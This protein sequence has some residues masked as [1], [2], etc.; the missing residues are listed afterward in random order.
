MLEESENSNNCCQNYPL[1]KI[2][3]IRPGLSKIEKN[4]FNL[5]FFVIIHLLLETFTFFLLLPR[6]NIFISFIDVHSTSFTLLYLSIFLFLFTYF[7]SLIYSDPGVIKK[8]FNYSLLQLIENN[9]KI[10]NYCPYCICPKGEMTKHCSYCERCV[11]NF[12]HHCYWVNNCIG[13]G[14]LLRFTWFI[15]IVVTNLIL[16]IYIASYCLSQKEIGMSEIDKNEDNAF[17]P[18]LKMLSP[19]YSSTIKSIYSWILLTICIC[20]LI[21]VMILLVYNVKNNYC[22]IKRKKKDPIKMEEETMLIKND[23]ENVGI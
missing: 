17:P 9:I 1:K 19:F 2:F 10:N 3:V 5:I 22:R 14:N 13:E 4:Y 23:A 16:H 21:P 7:V 15:F 11:K 20:F 18:F 8:K 12:D 6:K